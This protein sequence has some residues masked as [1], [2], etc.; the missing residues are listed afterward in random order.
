M[1][2]Q[3]DK[4]FISG[5]LISAAM[6]L[7]FSCDAKPKKSE[8]NSQ[9]FKAALTSESAAAN[10]SATVS[11]DHSAS[12]SHQHQG[13]D[14]LPVVVDPDSPGSCAVVAKNERCGECCSDVLLEDSERWHQCMNACAKA[15]AN[16]HEH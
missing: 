8:Q 12:S 5:L 2:S 1:V 9:Q 16:S 15:E 4:N 3:N 7:F 13:G 10:L 11:G 6:T 14:Q